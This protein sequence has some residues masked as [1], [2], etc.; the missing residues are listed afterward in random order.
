MNS[1]PSLS[2]SW[3]LPSYPFSSTSLSWL[4]KVA[5]SW[6][7]FNKEDIFLLDLG[8]VM[9]QWNGPKASLSEKA[10]V[11]VCGLGVQGLGRGNP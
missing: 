9:I 5:L 6:N 11:G 2:G 10:R 8:K 7:S 4:W 3:Q 1:S